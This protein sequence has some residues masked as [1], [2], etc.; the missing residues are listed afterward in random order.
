MM[1]NAKGKRI[2]DETGLLSSSASRVST[3]TTSFIT[4]FNIIMTA[5]LLSIAVTG[6]YFAVTATQTNSV[7]GDRLDSIE[8]TT[9]EINVTLTNEIADIN[10][11]LTN[12]IADVNSSLCTKIME[13]NTTLSQ[14]IL[15]VEAMLNLTNSTLN[16][17]TISTGTGL[18]GGPFMLSGTISLADTAVVPGTYNF[19]TLTVDQQGR[20]TAASSGTPVTSITTST[21]LT[22]GTITSTGTLALADTIVIPGTY[23]YSTVT[24]DPQGRLTAAYSG[25]NPVTSITGGTGLTGGTI[26]STGTLSLANTAVTAG[27]Y[28]FASIVVDPQGRLTSASTGV[29]VTSI[30]AGTGLTGGTI[31][32]TGTIAL[33][34][35]AVS[36]GAYTFASFTVDQQGRLTAAN[37]EVPVTSVTAGFG[38]T[39]GTIT[40]TGTIALADTPVSPGTFNFAT[41]SVDQKGRLTFAGNGVPVTSI[42]AGVGLNGGTITS[43]GTISLADTTVTTGSY[44]YA[45]ITVDA[46]G[47]L[48]SAS[49][50][51][52]YGPSIVTLNNDVTAIQNALNLINMTFS[53]EGDSL[54]NTLITLITNVS[55]LTATAATV[56]SVTAG[57]GLNG[58]VITTSGT[59]DL[60]NTAVTPGTYNFASL[61]VDQQGR[62]TY[63]A[64][65]S[66][67]TSV[68]AGTGLSGGIITTAGTLSIADT[69]VTP[70]TYNYATITVDQQGRLTFAS[71]GTVTSGTVTNIV[72]G[73]GL[74]GGP[75]TSTGTISLAD[76]IVT[77]G[78]YTYGSFTVD[79]Q[80]RLT[81]ASSGTNPVT[82]ITASTGLTGGTIT[83][84]GTIALA[85]TVVVPGS[86]TYGSFTVDQQGRLTAASSG[87]NPVTNITTGTGLTGG[88]ITSTGTIAL[89]N[90]I[91][92]PG[93]YTYAAI[94]VDQQG[95]LTA[96]SS[97]TSPV[98]SIATGTGLTGGT[99]T[100]TGTLSL[101]D[102]AVTP[103]SYTYGSF[104][105]DQQGRLTAAS[106]GTNPVTSVTA[107]TGLNGGTITSTG[108][109]D[110]ANTAVTSGSYTFASLTVD[111]Q[112]RLTAAS[113][114]VDYGQN[115]SM[116]NTQ[117]AGIMSGLNMLNSTLSM[118]EF[119]ITTFNSTLVTLIMD[120]MDL[121]TT[122]ATVQSVTAGTG[123]T[124]GV[125]TTTGTISLADTAVTPGTYTHST[126]TVDQQGRITSAMSGTA[127]SGTVTSITAGTGLTGGTITTS[128]TIAIDTTGVTAA[129]Y[130][131]G[132]F[133]VN[134][135]GQLVTASSNTP[136]VTSITAGSGLNGGTIT[137]TGTISLPDQSITP[138]TYNFATVTVDQKG[139]ITSVSSGS[140]VTSVTA[141]SGLTGGTI[142]ST[143]TIALSTTTVMAGSYTLASITVD[144]QGR[145]TAASS[146]TLPALTYAVIPILGGQ[147]LTTAPTNIQW[148]AATFDNGS[149]RTSS[150]TLTVNANGL[151]QFTGTGLANVAVGVTSLSLGM[152]VNGVLE[153]VVTFTSSGGGG[154]MYYDFDFV[155]LLNNGD[156][157]SYYAVVNGGPATA[158]TTS[159]F[160]R[161]NL[162]T[163][164]KLSQ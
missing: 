91:V 140:P 96:A 83:A 134:A 70:G 8:A 82:S 11:T 57:I 105:V 81:A 94:T 2:S 50:G 130:T 1:R 49:S 100:S 4:V 90:T 86:Y 28:N 107:G 157:L 101:A 85:D 65:G 117:V 143:G 10:V 93:S 9:I 136:P 71:T 161:D 31:T 69:S 56:Q 58:G 141:G 153:K 18:T 108:T 21:G 73:T 59:I 23:T 139:R 42:T 68:T 39:G 127:T 80:G 120:V 97:G 19:V 51:T 118:S 111:A 79:Q 53:M 158:T 150:T 116:L 122:A 32:S 87:T 129:S 92:T 7:Q 38:L 34:N 75:I 121:M 3:S 22:G 45:S 154:T 52:D 63:A 44:T 24:V 155:W 149:L 113:S 78:S 135:Q 48:T 60:A 103:G 159:N 72:T 20:L 95:R 109:I 40:S 160:A 66:P 99:I 76:T 27:S 137:S 35:T 6:V 37:S 14:E 119:N 77:P 46:Q 13:V 132:N 162:I 144:T 133:Q 126:I 142:T 125:I 55:A 30:T 89:A 115:I 156:V 147:A 26:T 148:G 102:T 16:N 47:R 110:L 67:V 88:T 62:L 151:W 124:G 123:L 84:T 15:I 12:E 164:T 36:P 74:T 17:V 5:A 145:L 114:G 61:T 146:G 41:L 43:T 104:T 54:N 98:T 152:R 128:G 64:S 131:W 138:A 25:T 33:A 112:G 29:P 106:S 163:L